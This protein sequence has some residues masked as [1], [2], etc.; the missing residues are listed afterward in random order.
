MGVILN[1]ADRLVNALTGTGTARDP[2]RAD[3]YS[4]IPLSQEQ[5]ASA[6]SGSPLIKKIVRIPAL[7]MVRE[8]RDFTGLEADQAALLFEHE[9]RHGLRQ[10]VLQV[11][12]LRGLGGGA[13]IMGLP[14]EPAQPAPA[15]VAK[16]GL[17]Y[18]NVVSRWHLTFQAMQDDARLEGY[19]E[20]AMWMLNTSRGQQPI[21]PSRVI[22]FR[23][24]TTATL[25]MPATWT[26]DHAF[27]GESTVQQV[28]EAVQDSDTARASFA[29]LMHKARL[30]R[31]GIPRLMQ[32]ASSPDGETQ[33][34]KRLAAVVLA[35]S[36][37]NATIYDAGDPETGNGGEK[38]DDATYSFAG[39]K[40][41]LN[42]YAEF[43]AAISDIPAT[44][45]LGRAPEG[46]N[47]SGESQQQDWNKKVRAMQTLDLAPCMDRLDRYLVPSA[48]GSVPPTCAYDFAPLDTPDQAVV[49]TR[50]KTQMEAV[51]SLQESGTIPDEA[52]ARGVQSLMIEEGYLPELESALAAMPDDERYGIAP[53][54]S[55]GGDQDLAGGDGLGLEA[56]PFRRAANDAAPRSLYVSR[57]VVNRADLQKWATAQGLG[58]LQPDLHVTIAY[59]RQP[60]DWM[61]IEGDDW[62]QSDDGTVTIKPGGVRIVEPLGNRTAVL[63][64]NSS[65]LAWRHEQIGRAGASW[66]YPDYQPHVSL[67]G[68]AVSLDGVEPYQGAIVLGPE[69]FEEVAE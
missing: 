42:S 7:D 52:F 44:R 65:T 53:D 12:V 1:M 14:G 19:G 26:A 5:I 21:H 39:A 27:W 33:I 37:H 25:A 30:L 17:A 13:L 54:I 20:P 34:Q 23:A 57:P 29:A 47:S 32:L 55:E 62:N 46:M 4:A 10:K 6:Y 60:L 49:A 24:D 28:L 50:F 15:T 63:L 3:T 66:D 67:T 35:E 51:R 2:R 16:D 38:I 22:P 41:I 56:E 9:K 61:K 40:D 64:F 36:I 58:E 43:V 48:I 68:E 31:I 18:I 8:W 11:E 45:L 69:R 59:S